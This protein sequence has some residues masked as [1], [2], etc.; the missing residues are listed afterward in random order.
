MDGTRTKMKESF[1]L[2]NLVPSI[3]NIELTFYRIHLVAFAFIPLIFSGIFY[4]CNGRFRISY[5]NSLF[6]CYSAMTL[7]G[8]TTVNLSTLTVS[9]Q[10]MLYLLMMMVSE[11]VDV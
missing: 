2:R 3:R 4:A 8:L 11:Y 10:V 6:L 7:T 9:Q 5:L 1:K